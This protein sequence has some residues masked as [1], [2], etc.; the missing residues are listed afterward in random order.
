MI[1]GDSTVFFLAPGSLVEAQISAETAECRDAAHYS[2]ADM[3]RFTAAL[4]AGDEE[5]FRY[6]HA[7]WNSRLVRYCFA[8]A[9]GDDLRASEL[10]QATYLRVFRHIRV[11]PDEAALWAWLA[12]A[13][14]SAAC[15][16]HRTGGR[17]QRALGRFAEW[18]RFRPPLPLDAGDDCTLLAALDHALADL[19]EEERALVEA[20]YFQRLPL[21]MIGVR[22]G[23]STRAIEGRLARIRTRLRERI[24]ETLQPSSD[25]P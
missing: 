9:A 21:E 14:K 25:L 10:A 6:L 1:A 19:S 5:A 2:S 18:L 13:A 17:Y 11:L 20:R 7:R 12:C 24:A 4:R 3:P 23:I 15:D 8:L 16:L 22:L